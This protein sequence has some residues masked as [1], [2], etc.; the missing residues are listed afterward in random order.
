MSN[1]KTR[2]GKLTPD[3]LAALATL[4][5]R[6]RLFMRAGRGVGA[7]IGAEFDLVQIEVLLELLPLPLGRFPVFRSRPGSE[8]GC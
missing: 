5:Q 6:G 3:K 4:G 7:S 1:I 8:P 2:R